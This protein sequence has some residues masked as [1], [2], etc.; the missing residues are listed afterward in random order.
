MS[1]DCPTPNGVAFAF[2]FQHSSPPALRR[3]KAVRCLALLLPHAL[4]GPRQTVARSQ[5]AFLKS[6]QLHVSFAEK[7]GTCP[8]ATGMLSGSLMTKAF[9]SWRCAVA[10]NK[11]SG[12][13]MLLKSA[14]KQNQ[15]KDVD[16]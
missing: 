8:G 16:I 9:G 11:G 10:R 4:W 2:S 12:T 15:A 1:C 3:K 7:S 6:A 14:M 13:Q 5:H